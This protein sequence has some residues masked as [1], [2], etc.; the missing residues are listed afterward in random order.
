MDMERHIT[1]IQYRGIYL[2]GKR[3]MVSLM[4]SFVLNSTD[5]WLKVVW[6]WR[7]NTAIF[8]MVAA[9]VKMN[10]RSDQV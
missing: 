1:T 5:E 8:A 3:T 6:R 4:D 2:W 7:D 9:K 10:A